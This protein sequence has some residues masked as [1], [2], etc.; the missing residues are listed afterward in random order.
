MPPRASNIPIPGSHRKIW[1]DSRHADA[2]SGTDDIHLTAWLRPK[3]GGAIDLQRVEALGSEPPLERAY[4]AR[5]ILADETGADPADVALLRAY[6]ESFGLTIGQSHWRSVVVNGSLE[7]LIQ[8]FGATVA[9]FEDDGGRRFRHRSEALHAPP[10]VSAVLLGV[11]GLHQWPRS[12]RIP[13]LNRH[14]TPLQARDVAARYDFPESD[15]RGQT[16]AVLQM[17]GMFQTSDFDQCMKAQGLAPEPPIVKAVDGATVA[18]A[19]ATLKD[20]EATLDV[21]IIASL[22]PAARI[23]VYEAPNDERGF[24]DAVRKAVFDEELAPSVLSISY[25]WPEHLWTPA[26]LDILNDLLAVAALAGVS[27]FCSSGDNGAELDYD[28]KPH[29]LAPASSSFAMGCGATVIGDDASQEQAWENTG[30]GFSERFG[31]PGWQDR[32]AAAAQHYEMAPGRGVPDV[33]AQQS[34]G[35]YV[36]MDGTELAMGGTSAVA[37]VWSALAARINQRLGAPIGF[38]LPILYRQFAPPVTG[39]VVGGGNGRFNAGEGWN[40][41]TGL[42]V[43]IGKAIERALRAPR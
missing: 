35:Y 18:H 9:I 10:E 27:V 13:A 12:R 15:G 5:G 16:I 34:P 4:A 41:C 37:P 26:A 6:C 1:P 32:T 36:V 31:I 2:V 30:G 11:F 8:A 21:Q 3:R 7:R 14:A 42:G 33:A 38:F 20:L 28:G 17:R 19:K 40:P 39:A 29:V 24:L 43:P 22:V 25:G 23:V